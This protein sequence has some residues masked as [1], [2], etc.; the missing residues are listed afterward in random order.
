MHKHKT[1]LRLGALA[2]A[3]QLALP[4]QAATETAR[5]AYDM[6]AQPLGQ[7]LAALAAKTGLL[8]ASD[9]RLLAGRQAPALQGSYSAEEALARLLADSDLV[10]VPNGQGLSLKKA[11]ATP[12]AGPVALLQEVTVYGDRTTGSAD[13]SN[14]SLAIAGAETLDNP[15]TSAWRDAF[16]LMANVS[17]GDSV[18]SGFVIRGIN[19]EGLT[20][21]GIGAPLASFYLDGVQQTVEGTRRGIRGSFDMEQ[22]EVYRGP[23]STLSGR[24]ALAGAIYLRSKDPEFARSGRVQL[25]RG[26]DDRQQVG[27]AYGDVLGEN[28]AFRISGEWAEKESDLKYPS[29]RRFD[30]YDDFVT[31]E[32]YNLRGKLL[33]K[34]AGSSDT[35]VLL[36]YA[37]AFDSPMSNTIAGPNWSTGA[38]SYKARR[39][40]V[41]GNI[42]PDMYR[43]GFGLTELPAFQDVRETAVDNA[44]LEITHVLSD[45]LTLTAQSGWTRSLTKRRSINEGTA[46]EFLTVDGE[47]DQSILAQEIR[48]NHDSGALRWVT[49]AYAAREEQRAFRDQQ[50]LALDQTRNGAEITN[51]A[52]FGETSW[53]FVT[54]WRVI[55]GGRVDSVRQRQSA[56]YAQNGA[57]VSDTRSGFD[58][59]ALLPKLGLEH[60]FVGNQRVSLIYREGYRPGGAGTQASTGA[61]YEYKPENARNIELSWQGRFADNRLALTATAFHQDWQDQQVELWENP[62]DPNSSKVVNAGKSVSYGA[63]LEASYAATRELQ[64]YTAIGLLRTEFKDFQVGASDYSGRPFPGAPKF[65]A[66]LGFRYGHDTGWLASGN[67]AHASRSM[68]RLQQNLTTLDG[69]TTVDASL[70]YGWHNGVRL[71][72]YAANLFDE[73][74]FKYEDGPGVMATLGDRR[75]AGLRLDYR[76]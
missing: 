70:G 3:M 34:P 49:G 5:H 57:M 55:V 69:H 32:S 8:I 13:A 19:S 27:L 37:H 50:L 6:P 29:Y 42:L 25:T 41:W 60:S 38:P 36:S 47:F 7:A 40:D 44:G 12:A 46:G 10:A 28:V 23:Q 15:A 48:L 63:E 2:L 18:E 9:A 52:L 67:I 39:G 74:Y 14:S 4:A 51:L 22:L 31:D 65:N 45:T 54:D 35:R 21:G 64:I 30:R 11:P 53:E 66:T 17:T 62:I 61:E 71:T 1:L 58:D 20:P 26:E 56:F 16:R 68:S 59:V 76:F 73:E 72:A 75:E 24:N 43:F 33:W